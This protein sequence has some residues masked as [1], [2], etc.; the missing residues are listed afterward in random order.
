MMHDTDHNDPML[1]LDRPNRH[2]F[3]SGVNCAVVTYILS[4]IE[5][6]V[7]GVVRIESY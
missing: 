2:R 1:Q 5:A 4:C 7:V 6:S 3:S